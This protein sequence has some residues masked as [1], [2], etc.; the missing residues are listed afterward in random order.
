MR[1]PVIAPTGMRSYR[2]SIRARGP[3]VALLIPAILG[4]VSLV[5]LHNSTSTSHGIGGFL[6]AMLAV[7]LLPAFGVPIRSGGSTYLLAV[8]ASAVVWMVVGLIASRR[9]TRAPFARWGTYWGEYLML[10]LSV[11]GGVVLSLVAAN[12][13]MGRALL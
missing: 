9:A 10:A 6:A 8:L 11:W 2:R 13:V 12:L 1:P 3:L 7:P 4:I 5:L